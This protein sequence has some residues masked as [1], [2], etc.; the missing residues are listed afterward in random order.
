[1]HC[2]LFDAFSTTF[3]YAASHNLAGPLS[4]VWLPLC[5]IFRLTIPRLSESFF[6]TQGDVL[7]CKSTVHHRAII[8]PETARKTDRY[9]STNRL[10]LPGLFTEIMCRFLSLLFSFLSVSVFDSVHPADSFSPA[11]FLNVYL[12]VS[13]ILWGCS[14]GDRF[15]LPLLVGHPRDTA[16]LCS[17][18]IRN[19]NPGSSAGAIACIRGSMPGVLRCV[20]VHARMTKASSCFLRPKF[21]AVSGI[22]EPWDT[23]YR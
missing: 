13:P 20:S 2:I 9:H 14:H 4:A 5:F 15:V 19:P 17:D 16:P 7:S 10:F 6:Q 18:R 11:S 3:H 22:W 23:G 8:S 12:S 21:P 1:M